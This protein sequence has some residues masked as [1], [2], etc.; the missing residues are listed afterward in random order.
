MT[1]LVEGTAQAEVP[2]P[3]EH[4]W[5]LLTDD[6]RAS[7]RAGIE[8]LAVGHV[9]GTP[10]DAVGEMACVVARMPDGSL[11]GH[12]A[13]LVTYEPTRR[14]TTRTRCQ[15]PASV[16]TWTLAPTPGG[17]GVTVRGSVVVPVA[18]TG[19]WRRILAHSA[20]VSLWHLRRALGDPGAGRAPALSHVL[21]VVERLIGAAS[22]ARRALALGTAEVTRSAPLPVPPEVVWA[23][24]RATGSPVVERGDQTALCFAPDEGP[25]D[26]VGGVRLVLGRQP[27]ADL[28]LLAEETVAVVPGAHLATRDLALGGPA[29]DVVVVPTPGGCRLEVRVEQKVLWWLVG[30]AQRRLA[31][32][33]DAYLDRVARR[34][35]GAPPLPLELGWVG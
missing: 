21:R 34:V 25:T 8:P 16:V 20:G 19:S 3:V 11:N 29:A 22:A 10:R 18:R 35:S 1:S 27:L 6:T 30:E 32:R 12:V 26:V 7:E 17:C 28:M 13:E 9:P 4:V 5:A 24:V 14:V 33:A 15:T 2:F 31:R 23:V